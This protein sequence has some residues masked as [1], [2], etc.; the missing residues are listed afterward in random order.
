MCLIRAAE[1]PSLCRRPAAPRGAGR[2]VAWQTNF[3]DRIVCFH[4]LTVYLC[5]CVCVVQVGD[6]EGRARDAREALRPPGLPR[7]R[8]ALEPPARLLPEAQTDQQPPGP[9][10]TRESSSSEQFS[11]TMFPNRSIKKAEHIRPDIKNNILLFYSHNHVPLSEIIIRRWQK[12]K[13]E[14]KKIHVN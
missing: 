6:G 13:R 3:C 14:R 11:K 12:I 5:G 2:S 8:S 10:W 1:R 7:H 9:V 4:L